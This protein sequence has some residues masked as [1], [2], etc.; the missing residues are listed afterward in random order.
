[1]SDIQPRYKSSN[2]KI[3]PTNISTN[4]SELRSSVHSVLLL[5]LTSA[6]G[7][8]NE[9]LLHDVEYRVH[10]KFLVDCF[11]LSSLLWSRYVHG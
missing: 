10:I 3:F 7:S 1:M 4:V 6:S 5:V 9:S 2:C 8:K 11:Y